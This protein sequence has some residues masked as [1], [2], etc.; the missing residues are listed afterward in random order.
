MILSASRRTDIPAFYSDWFYNRINQGYLL[1]RNPM[2]IHKISKI[3]ILPE[4][5]DC[6]VFWTKNPSRFMHR[7]NELQKYVFYF[8][9]TIIGYGKKYEPNVPSLEE[10]IKCFIELSKMIGPNRVIWRYD[11]IIINDEYNINYHRVK[12]NNI[13]EQLSKYTKRCVISFID[14]YKNI[15]RNMP[16]VQFANLSDDEMCNVADKLSIIGKEYGIT[17]VSCAERINLKKYGIEHGKCIDDKLVEEIS[18]FPLKIGK[19]K[20][21]RQECG[22]VASIDIGAYNTCQHGCIYCYATYDQDQARRNYASHDSKSDIIVG[23]VSDQDEIIERKVV[24]CK[25]LRQT[26]FD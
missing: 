11:P 12:F 5:V 23:H 16:L 4:V 15:L 7:I 18:G 14:Y 1:V 17:I 20:S 25:V 6:I 19:D 26:L 8:Q 13:A 3:N 22:C 21:Q 2:N 9:Y 10:S 24:S